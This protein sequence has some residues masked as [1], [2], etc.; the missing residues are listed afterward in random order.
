MLEKSE[1]K[2][3]TAPTQEKKIRFA[4]GGSDD[5]D[6]GPKKPKPTS[7]Q[8]KMLAMAGQDIDSFMKEVSLCKTNN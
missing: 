5:E 1:I 8:Q 4:D 3:K 6:D 7:L 2:E